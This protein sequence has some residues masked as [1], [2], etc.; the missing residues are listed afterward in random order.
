MPFSPPGYL[1]NPGIEPKSPISPVLAGRFFTTAPLEKTS[2]SQSMRNSIAE[3]SPF[4]TGIPVS[5]PKNFSLLNVLSW[6]LRTPVEGVE[7]E[8][9]Q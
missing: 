6:S 9:L 5:S 8:I 1:P 7:Y 3:F 4:G 2:S